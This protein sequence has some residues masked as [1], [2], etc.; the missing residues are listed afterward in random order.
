M[1]PKPSSCAE[2][3]A[4]DG[5]NAPSYQRRGHEGG[6]SSSRHHHHVALLTMN[7]LNP[8]HRIG[9]PKKGEH[10]RTKSC[11]SRHARARDNQKDSTTSHHPRAARV[12]IPTAVP[13]VP[14][15]T[16][17]QSNPPETKQRRKRKFESSSKKQASLK[18]K[19]EDL[20]KVHSS[21]RQ[22]KNEMTKE[23]RRE[24]K[25]S[26]LLSKQSRH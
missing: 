6:S 4:E 5:I 12:P 3:S 11:R 19:N 16:I 15:D 23:L 7:R 25:V 2:S 10:Q 22:D 24:K 18:M 14:Y 20:K 9:R 13:T 26:Q 8:P 17:S 21:L 1:A